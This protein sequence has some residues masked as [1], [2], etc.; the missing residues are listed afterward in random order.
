MSDYFFINPSLPAAVNDD[1]RAPR[2]GRP[3][4]RGNRTTVASVLPQVKKNNE[5]GK[6][7]GK[8]ASDFILIMHA[9]YPRTTRSS[10]SVLIKTLFHPTNVYAGSWVEPTCRQQPNAKPTNVGFKDLNKRID[11]YKSKFDKSCFQN[12]IRYIHWFR[13]QSISITFFLFFLKLDSVPIK[14]MQLESI[15]NFIFPFKLNLF[16]IYIFLN[17][18]PI[19][20]PNRTTPGKLPTTINGLIRLLN[21]LCH[22]K[23]IQTRFFCLVSARSHFPVKNFFLFPPVVSNHGDNF[24]RRRSKYEMPFLCG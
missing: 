12:R 4:R 16:C 11:F 21:Q 7:H 20:V 15:F 9:P 14:I 17:L 23:A 24:E 13:R 3:R 5:R 8:S 22:T 10:Y 18:V 19:I 1:E 6:I 2:A